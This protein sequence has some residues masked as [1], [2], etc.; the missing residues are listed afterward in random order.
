MGPPP[1][2]EAHPRG[3]GLVI[4]QTAF[5][6]ARLA[7]QIVRWATERLARRRAYSGLPYGGYSRR[8]MRRVAGPLSVS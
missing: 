3:L 5:A 2:A 4:R 6:I 7:A 8:R 1:C